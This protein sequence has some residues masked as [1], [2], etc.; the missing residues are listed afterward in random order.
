MNQSLPLPMTGVAWQ[1]IFPLL[2]LLHP[3]RQAWPLLISLIVGLIL[4]WA[5]M[6]FWGMKLWVGTAI[7]LVALLPA[8]SVK[9]YHDWLHYGSKTIVIL[10]IL[11]T[12]QGAHTIEHIVQWVQYHILFWT[13]RQSSGLLSPANAEWVHFVWNWSVLI[14]VIVLMRGGLRNGWAY[15]LLG[16]ALLHTFEHTYAFIRYQ[17]VLGELRELGVTNVTA[18]GLPGILGRDGWLARSIWTRGTIICSVP[19]LTTATRLDVHFWWNVIEMA[20]LT[21]AGHVYL[22]T[23]ARR[24]P[25]E[26]SVGG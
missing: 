15:L 4:G 26:N 20:L 10:S 7:V 2:A 8:L 13:A 9:F 18:Q 23:W 19:G 1:R 22:L 11:L 6:Q 3:R 16:V 21:A 5:A 14:L 25:Q 24:Q 12:A 17:Q